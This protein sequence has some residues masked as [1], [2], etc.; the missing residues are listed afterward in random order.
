MER[1]EKGKIY[2]SYDTIGEKFF[3][4]GI[5]IGGNERVTNNTRVN[6]TAIVL[7]PTK[8]EFR[9]EMDW[10]YLDCDRKYRLATEEEQIWLLACIEKGKY[11][12]K[13]EA[14]KHYSYSI[15]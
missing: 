7:S 6:D 13:E 5:H 8:C 1:L 15:Y 9:G 3:M 14:L 10:C 2:Y 12:P 11:I 4:I